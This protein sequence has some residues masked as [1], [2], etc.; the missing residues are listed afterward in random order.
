MNNNAFSATDEEQDDSFF[1]QNVTDGHHYV[2]DMGLHFEPFEVKDLYM[3]DST[4]FKKS[5]DIRKSMQLGILARTSREEADALLDMEI[6]LIQTEHQR[7]IDQRE[8]RTIDVNGKMVVA[9]TFDA[10]KAGGQTKAGLVSTAGFAN[11]HTSYAKAFQ[12]VRQAEADRGHILTAREF[13]EMVNNDPNLVRNVMRNAPAA[14]AWSGDPGRGKATFAVPSGGE[15]DPRYPGS[16]YLTNFNRD[17]R[18]AGADYS[19]ISTQQN[20][21]NADLPFAEEI[22]VLADDDDES[23][24]SDDD[25]PAQK[26]AVKRR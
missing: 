22:D 19:R 2:T 10:A 8:T 11:D 3:E 5:R 24:Y 18:L 4:L 23:G 7:E 20:N 17:Q 1:V 12:T 16:T 26:G 13:S 21:S 6:A 9:D 25:A 15:G 14:G